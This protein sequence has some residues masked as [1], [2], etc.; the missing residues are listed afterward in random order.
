MILW[1][2]LLFIKHKPNTIIVF[3]VKKKENILFQYWYKTIVNSCNV[4]FELDCVKVFMF[5]AFTQ[6]DQAC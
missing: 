6:A 5:N 1:G 2:L 4:L 3:F